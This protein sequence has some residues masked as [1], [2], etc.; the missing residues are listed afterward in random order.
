MD[1]GASMLAGIS[2]AGTKALRDPGNLLIE[3]HHAKK[4]RN[5][6]QAMDLYSQ[7][8]SAAAISGDE[9]VASVVPD[10]RVNLI[11]C[12]AQLRKF[13][14]AY[15]M[16]SELDNQFGQLRLALQLAPARLEQR[17]VRSNRRMN[18]VYKHRVAPTFASAGRRPL[19]AAQSGY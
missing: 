19:N 18:I 12:C 9:N 4:R 10:A 16:T 2:G 14:D 17:F 3:G 8:L 5:Y 13:E 7:C 15:L 1:G 11:E 6:R